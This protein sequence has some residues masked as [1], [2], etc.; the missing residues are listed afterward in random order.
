MAGMNLMGYDAM[1]LGPNE[2]GLGVETLDERLESARFP[3]LSANVVVSGTTELYAEPY[4]LLDVGNHRLGV[5][6]L[7]RPPSE[8][9]AGF[10]VLDP[11]EA[12]SRFVPEVGER[13]EMVV[14]LT[15]LS[16]R[17][18]KRL[19]KEVP[20][21]DLVIAALPRQLPRQAVTVPGTETVTVAAEQAMARHSGRRVGRLLITFTAEGIWNVESWDSV[22]MTRDLPDD[23]GMRDLLLSFR[24]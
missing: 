23:L 16:H 2:L 11:R 19:A 10:Q 17:A 20:G 12:A 1:A 5:V 14:V 9:I 22:A 15:N 18:A 21:I 3:M 4:A 13:A 6:G 7:T 24:E 8:S